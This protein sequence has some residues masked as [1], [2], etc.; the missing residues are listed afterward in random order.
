MI[1]NARFVGRRTGLALLVVLS[2]GTAAMAAEEPP[3]APIEAPVAPIEAPTVAPAAPPVVPIEAPPVA[4]IEAPLP[5]GH[6]PVSHGIVLPGDI[7][8]HGRFDIAYERY[9]Y[10]DAIGDGKDAFRNY[11]RFLFLERHVKDDPFY[12]NAEVLSVAF[13]EMGAHL[14][15]GGDDIWRASVAA[16]KV[17]VPFGADPLFHHAYG[18]RVG[19]DQRVLPFVWGEFG[20]KAALELELAPVGLRID[21]YVVRGYALRGADGLINL[22]T[23]A[24]PLDDLNFSGGGRIS[25]SLGPATMSYSVYGGTLDY[26]RWLLMQA[27][28]ASLWRLDVPVLEDIAITIGAMRADVWGGKTPAYYHFADYLQIRYYPID[29][30]V[31]ISNI[32]VVSTCATIGAAS[33]PTRRAST[34]STR[35]PTASRSDGY[36]AI[37]RSFCSTSGSSSS[38]TSSPTT[39]SASLPPTSFE[40]YVP[41]SHPAHPDLHRRRLLR[42]RARR[43]EAQG[44]CRRGDRAR[45]D[46]PHGRGD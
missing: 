5:P 18:G 35:P 8:L 40:A 27:F 12:F 46:R 11:H 29:C 17:L 37:S 9:G 44:R 10:S 33:S 43:P 39:F 45:D 32:V 16:G 31:C 30:T 23:N 13:Y 6:P 25:A 28:D 42:A 24:A 4:P 3:V 14:Q 21:A 36:T 2:V 7:R 15:G 20:L 1:A 22:Q 19:A 41:T 38:S 34:S 26:D